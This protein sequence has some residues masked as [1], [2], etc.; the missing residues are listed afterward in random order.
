MVASKSLSLSG[1]QFPPLKRGLGPAKLQ[2][3]SSV[4]NL[5]FGGQVLLFRNGETAWPWGM[6]GRKD[7]RGLPGGKRVQDRVVER[8]LLDV[9]F[10][11]A[12]LDYLQLLAFL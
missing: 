6:G 3:T 1:A 10:F 11:Q 8:P 9:R 4:G 12:W 5:C 7:R 2:S